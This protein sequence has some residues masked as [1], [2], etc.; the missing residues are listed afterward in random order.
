MQ[1]DP[2]APISALDDPKE[3]VV[4]DTETTGLDIGNDE[5]IQIAA[6][7][8]QN[9]EIVDRL[10]LFLETARPIPPMLGN[11]PNPMIAEYAAHQEELVSAEVA[12]NRF[13]D[14]VGDAPVVGHNVEYD[15]NIVNAQYALLKDQLRRL[16]RTAATQ[17]DKAVNTSELTKRFDTLKL[18]HALEPLICQEAGIKKLPSHKLKDLIAVLRLEGLNSHKADDDV[19]ATVHLLRWFYEHSAPLMEAQIAI[20]KISVSET[21]QAAH[22]NV[23]ELHRR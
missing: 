1:R 13:L 22:R 9:G 23:D 14:F 7:K 5:V 12:F 15:A 10:V 18:S 11:I 2:D 20:L 4:F 17:R 19:E 3:I 6:V 8:L 21:L 16:H